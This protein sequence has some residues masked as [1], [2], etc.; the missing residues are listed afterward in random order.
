MLRLTNFSNNRIVIIALKNVKVK[1]KMN[2]KVFLTF[3]FLVL[4][5]KYAVVEDNLV[6]FAEHVCKIRPIIF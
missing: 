4:L 6:E 1:A 2:A 3:T 5:G